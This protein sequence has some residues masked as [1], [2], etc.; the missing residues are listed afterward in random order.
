[1]PTLPVTRKEV[2]MLKWF[3]RIAFRTKTKITVF[4]IGKGQMYADTKCNVYE[5]VGN[6]LLLIQAVINH[7]VPNA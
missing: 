2:Q 1:M 7:K 5:R 6:R 4:A 3:K